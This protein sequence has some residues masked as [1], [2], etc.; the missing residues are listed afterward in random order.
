MQGSRDEL[1][2][3]LQEKLFE[4]EVTVPRASRDFI[5]ANIRKL[6][7]RRA[8]RR[9]GYLAAASFLV[10]S[11]FIFDNGVFKGTLDTHQ[12]ASVVISKSAP[13]AAS[14]PAQSAIPNLTDN[15]SGHSNINAAYNGK[16]VKLPDEQQVQSGS[17]ETFTPMPDQ[18]HAI[19]QEDLQSSP[20]ATVE[21][22]DSAHST[23]DDRRDVNKKE[24]QIMNR[25][26][27][28]QRRLRF[29]VSVMPLLAFA[30][31][32]PSASDGPVLTGFSSPAGMSPSRLGARV[33]FSIDWALKN[34]RFLYAG[35]SYFNY[36]TAFTYNSDEAVG[37]VSVKNVVDQRLS[38]FGLSAGARYPLKIYGHKR[39]Y[40]TGGIETQILTGGR[41]GL[42][43]PLQ[44]VLT[45][46]YASE[47]A[48]SRGFLRLQPTLSYYLSSVHFPG[49]QSHP[50]WIGFDVA[51]VW[52]H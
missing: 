28:L 3:I 41:P 27:D 39:R 21:K 18:Y 32:I 13:P 11:Y 35:L 20:M 4:Y 49:L 38:G 17:N 30:N 14:T 25:A 37:G 19:V 47:V 9:L 36:R 22:S 24:D 50:Y 1:E 51:Y 15:F 26:P 7:R 10:T 43:A 48:L 40:V 46:G 33:A 8:N 12:P 2:E 42:T 29:N 52:Q 16:S 45:G 23:L 31:V 34:N 44:I 6:A 5:F